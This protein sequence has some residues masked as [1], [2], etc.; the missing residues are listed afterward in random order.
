MTQ[1]LQTQRTGKSL[2]D[3]FNSYTEDAVKRFPGLNGRLVVLDMNEEKVYVAD[4]ARRT[5]LT[6]E[7]AAHYMETRQ[8][9]RGQPLIDVLARNPNKGTAS[10]YDPHMGLTL[11]MNNERID[12]S[13]LNNVSE[14]SEEQLLYAM[15]HELGH[16]GIDNGSY[17]SRGDGSGNDYATMI[18][19]SVA[20][21]YAL[22]RHYQRFGTGET[23][24]KY[25]DPAKRAY[26]MI[27]GGSLGHFTS[28]VLEEIAQQ[29]DRIDF[30]SLSPGIHNTILH[31]VFPL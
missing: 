14:A 28:F 10:T 21:A 27:L 1:I 19:E 5:G 18:G 9:G 3:I 8:D 12:K 11:I 7:D 29:K 17:A 31:D 6:G 26:D 25:V 30:A 20:D 13:E 15:D 2:T 24:D 16:W 23:S 4:A 22:I